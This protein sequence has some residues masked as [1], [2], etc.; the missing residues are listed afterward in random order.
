ML[1]E[2]GLILL[3]A[4]EFFSFTV[5]EVNNKDMKKFNVRDIGLFFH[6]N[7]VRVAKFLLYFVTALLF[8]SIFAWIFNE[9]RPTIEDELIEKQIIAVPEELKKPGRFSFNDIVIQPERP[10]NKLLYL[11]IISSSA[12]GRKHKDRRNAIRHTWGN[13]RDKTF[14]DTMLSQTGDLKYRNKY[15]GCRI[16]FYVGKSENSLENKGIEEEAMLNNDIIVVDVKE[17]YRNITWKL[18]T[19]IKF[20]SQFD[21]KF[22][23]KTDDDVYIYLPRLTKY[24]ATGVGFFATIY[25]GTTYTGKV[26]R[27]PMHRH[28][29]AKLDYS[30]TKYPL[31][32]KG[33]MVLLSGDLLPRVVDVFSH[34]K[35]F[36]IDDAY[37]GISLN[38]IGV[39]PLRLEKF[40]QFQ[41]LPVFLDYL[42]PCDFSWLVGVGDGLTAAKMYSVHKSMIKGGKLPQWMCLHFS[43]FPLLCIFS[44]LAVF[45]MMFHLTYAVK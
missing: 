33:S 30:E 17:H 32:C 41:H 10:P 26:V 16:I 39:V 2:C 42:H 43:W 9:R 45:C 11:I 12:K 23:L 18:R 15:S 20:I 6:F 19:T 31:F 24:I 29:V 35:P 44:V 34:V 37:L 7:Y 4:K 5:E 8:L 27:D 25:G 40:V 3:L 38:K 36:N 22:I 14:N 21:A 28:Y 13:C 1:S